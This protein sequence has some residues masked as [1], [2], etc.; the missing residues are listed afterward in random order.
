MRLHPVWHLRLVAGAIVAGF[1]ATSQGLWP[2]PEVRA[3]SSYL[4]VLTLGYG[5]LFGGLWFSRGRIRA[6]Y[7]PVASPRLFTLFVWVGILNLFAFYSWAVSVLGQWLVLAFLGLASWHTF[8]N[9]TLLRR[10][11]DDAELRLGAIPRGSAYHLAPLGLTSLFLVLAAASLPEDVPGVEEGVL[12]CRLVAGSAGALLLMHRSRFA[13]QA[14]GAL[15]VAGALF[16]PTAL[17][18]TRPLSFVDVFNASVLYHLTSWLLFFGDRSRRLSDAAR[19]DLRRNLL[20]VHL[21]PAA[22]SLGLLAIPASA[23]DAA[24][25]WAFSPAVYLFWSVAHVLQTLAVRGLEPRT[26]VGCTEREVAG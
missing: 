5:H 19:R 12:L 22:L 15:L 18:R 3:G 1:V 4:L 7:P 14:I 9:D 2:D 20:A 21:A 10:A 16:L 11:Y 26:A 13:N 25:V 24:R 6:M 8:E 17:G 23:L